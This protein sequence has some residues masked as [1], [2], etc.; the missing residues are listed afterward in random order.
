MKAVR[1]MSPR[2]WLSLSSAQKAGKWG[3]QTGL[4]HQHG[5]SEYFLLTDF[6][7]RAE[8]EGIQKQQEISLEKQ[9]LSS[10]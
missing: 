6:S 5:L 8:S 10:L 2:G 7:S 1:Q 4:G 3:P 9:V